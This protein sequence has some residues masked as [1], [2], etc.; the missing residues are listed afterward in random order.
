MA[1]P[2]LAAPIGPNGPCP[3]YKVDAILNGQLDP[4]ACCSYGKCKGD[5]V[6][7]VGE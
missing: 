2:V 6:I 3:D 5:V 7:S 1:S 4:S